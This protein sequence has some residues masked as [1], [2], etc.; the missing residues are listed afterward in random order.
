MVTDVVETRF[1]ARYA[2]NDRSNLRLTYLFADMHSDDYAYQGLQYGGLSGVLPTGQRPPAY[3]VHVVY[4]AY[5][6]RF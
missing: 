2:L 4:V 1:N 3:A 6:A 5:G